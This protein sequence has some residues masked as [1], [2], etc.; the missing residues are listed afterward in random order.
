MSN[1]AKRRRAK[2]DHKRPSPAGGGLNITSNASEFLKQF[3][4]K[5]IIAATGNWQLMDGTM[6]P[7][8]TELRAHK[9]MLP[10]ETIEPNSAFRVRF[11]NF[12]STQYFLSENPGMFILVFPDMTSPGKAYL[13][14]DYTVTGSAL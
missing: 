12:A 7:S 8:I 9:I 10:L 4:R 2:R 5:M 3:E 13:V 14:P 11:Q 6:V 1:R